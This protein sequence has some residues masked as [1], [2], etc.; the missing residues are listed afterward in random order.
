M[1]RASSEGSATSKRVTT[2]AAASDRGQDRGG[3]VPGSSSSSANAGARADGRDAGQAASQAGSGLALDAQADRARAAGALQV[4]R[5]CPA[6]TT[7]PWSTIAT[8]SHSASAA[9]IWWVEKTIVRPSVAQLHER[10][11]QEGEVDRVEA[12]ERLVHEQHLRVVEDR[13]DELDLLLVALATAPRRA[14][15]A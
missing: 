11:A 3:S 15:S 8:D 14:A 4:A 9:S 12:G 5:A 1:K 10:L 7:R 2:R 13:R 6:T